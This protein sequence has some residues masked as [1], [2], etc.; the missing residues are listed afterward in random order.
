MF[1]FII[2]FPF[3]QIADVLRYLSL[4]NSLGNIFAIILYI[5]FCLMPIIPFFIKPLKNKLNYIDNLLPIISVLMFI[6]MYQLINPALI[7]TE[8]ITKAF[9]CITIWSVICTYL[10]LKVIKLFENNTIQKLCKYLIILLWILIIVMAYSILFNGI[11]T[12]TNTIKDLKNAN[13]G[14]SSQLN[15]TYLFMF[16]GF[17]VE[18]IPNIA[19][20]IVVLF[21]IS[22]VKCLNTN[23]YSEE[24][25]MAAN[26][27]S[28]ICKQ[29]LIITIIS[30][31]IFNVLQYA[32][33]SQLFKINSNINIPI[34]SIVFVLIMFVFSK[35][36]TFDKELKDDNDSII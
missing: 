1:E 10:I 19:N 29:A 32:F 23:R 30:T 2:T 16:F 4:S 13:S 22:F 26:K 17:I 28:T 6:V 7:N 21:G 35:I 14:Y 20:I 15:L 25:V 31:M 5:A 24:S 34:L 12:F 27:L 36:I 9:P 18:I 33:S 8:I 3:V 11:V